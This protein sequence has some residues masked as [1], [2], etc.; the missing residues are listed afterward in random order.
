MQ[1]ELKV[2]RRKWS[3]E[4][5]RIPVQYFIK[6]ESTRYKEGTIINISRSGA[7]VLFPLNEPLTIGA[8]VFLELFVPKSLEQLSLKGEV[9]TRHKRGDSLVGGIHFISLLPEELFIKLS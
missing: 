2:N 5:V 6:G 7:G 3:R 8:Q 1:E 4:T 9:K